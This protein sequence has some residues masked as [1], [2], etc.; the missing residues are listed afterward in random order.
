M[1]KKFT[2]DVLLVTVH[3]VS[4]TSNIDL[5]F[6]LLDSDMTCAEK[7]RNNISTVEDTSLRYRYL[8][9]CAGCFSTILTVSSLLIPRHITAKSC[10][11]TKI[12]ELEECTLSVCVKRRHLTNGRNGGIEVRPSEGGTHAQG[13]TDMGE[14]GYTRLRRWCF[15]MTTVEERMVVCEPRVK[16]A[17]LRLL[18]FRELCRLSSSY[19]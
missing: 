7:F 5:P 8:L 17:A 3:I 1:R 14:I 16:D 10:G 18:Q 2:V 6:L 19:S 9:S 11:D 4:Y 12:T 13:E 15:Q